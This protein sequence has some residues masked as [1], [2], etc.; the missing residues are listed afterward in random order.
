[1]MLSKKKA[2][3]VSAV[4]ALQD[5]DYTKNPE[6]EGIYS[7]LID[8]RSQFNA[9]MDRNIQA[10][11]EISSLDLALTFHTDNMIGIAHDVADE[12]NVISDA[13]VECSSVAEM[14]NS[15]HEELTHTIIEA[16]NETD[17][18]Y[19]KIE[20]GQKEL[21]SIRDLSRDKRDF[22]M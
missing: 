14:V 3:L 4:S 2:N 1:M 19:K 20:E 15:Q 5:A 10:V 7:R 18:V 11:M 9:V 13:A 21:S 12:T 22:F 17:E 16:S 6:L 8:G